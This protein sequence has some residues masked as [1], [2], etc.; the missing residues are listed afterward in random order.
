MEKKYI[1]TKQACEEGIQK[2]GSVCE[3]CGRTPIALE[4]ADNA[5]NPTH[6]AGCYHTDNVTSDS[7]GVF[8]CGV[9]PEVYKLAVNLVLED[10]DFRVSRRELIENEDH[11]EYKFREAVAMLPVENFSDILERHRRWRK[12]PKKVWRILEEHRKAPIKVLQMPKPK[13]QKEFGFGVAP[14]YGR[15]IDTGGYLIKNAIA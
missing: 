9:D 1:V 11:F 13:L 10:G 5:N 15:I 12:H 8:T 6:W 14:L 3:Y 7:W 2:R 4:T